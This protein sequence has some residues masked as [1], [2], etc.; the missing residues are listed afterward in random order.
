MQSSS[1][2]TGTNQASNVAYKQGIQDNSWIRPVHLF[3][4]MTPAPNK[5]RR[6]NIDSYANEQDHVAKLLKFGQLPD[7]EIPDGCPEI[8]Y[9]EYLQTLSPLGL[10]AIEKS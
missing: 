6:K 5:L 4:T 10:R 8:E 2:A 1:V 7:T 3:E 9:R